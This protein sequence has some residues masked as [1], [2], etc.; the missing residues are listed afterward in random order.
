MH[1]FVKNII[2]PLVYHLRGSFSMCL[3][4][5]FGVSSGHAPVYQENGTNEIDCYLVFL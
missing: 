2:S 1:Q 4:F 3:Y 5:G